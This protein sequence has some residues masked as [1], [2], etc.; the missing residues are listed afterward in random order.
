MTTNELKLEDPSNSI[1]ITLLIRGSRRYKPHKKFPRG[2][3]G[4]TG[5]TLK[6]NN[7]SAFI[8]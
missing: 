6:E 4:N 3:A 7:N 1:K 2:T 8:K 5:H